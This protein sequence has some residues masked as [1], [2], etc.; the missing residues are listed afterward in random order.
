L[1]LAA[2]ERFSRSR[3]ERTDDVCVAELLVGL[4]SVLAEIPGH[5]SHVPWLLKR[6]CWRYRNATPEQTLNRGE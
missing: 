2:T 6:N 4:G 3:V 5:Y 1:L